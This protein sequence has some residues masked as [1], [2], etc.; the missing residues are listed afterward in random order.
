MYINAGKLDLVLIS[1][2]QSS[3]GLHTV[4]VE[5]DGSFQYPLMEHTYLVMVWGKNNHAYFD[6]HGPESD[7]THN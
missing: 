3:E 4:L 6:F 2:L 7:G 5:G 1:M